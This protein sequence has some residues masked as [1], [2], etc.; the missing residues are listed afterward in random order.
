[1]AV[2]LDV[3][4]VDLMAAMMAAMTAVK[5]AVSMVDQTAVLKAEM[6]VGS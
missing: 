4:S 1:M 2:C 3:A 6:K 5:S